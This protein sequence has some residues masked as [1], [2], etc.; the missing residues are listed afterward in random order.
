LAFLSFL[1]L[2]L[3]A[4]TASHQWSSRY[5]DQYAQEA[6]SVAVDRDGYVIVAGRMRGTVDFGGGPLVAAG[7]NI[8]LAKFDPYGGHVWSHCFSGHGWEHH[9]GRLVF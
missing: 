1:H 4:D 9:V 6:M 3:H 5:G 2:T 7:D 8:F